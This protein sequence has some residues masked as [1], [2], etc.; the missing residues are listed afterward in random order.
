MAKQIFNHKQNYEG[1]QPAILK[2]LYPGMICQF[3]YSGKDIFDKNPL[4]L[5]LHREVTDSK[6]IHGLNLNYL[7]ETL[8][9]K[10]FCTCELLFKGAGVYSKEP[11]GR[12]I[13][14]GMSDYDDTLPNRNLLKENFTRIMLPTYKENRGGNPLSKSEAQK[15][16]KM[17][18]NKVVKKV[19]SKYQIYRTYTPEKM[20]TIKVV[21]YRLGEWH[22]PGV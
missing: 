19:I 10:L 20:K 18:Y 2:A 8:V 14:S 9:Q 4:I 5:L 6:L 7:P 16:M 13:Q 22:Q 3:K 12:Q 21:H 17:L 1:I 11:I 15:Q